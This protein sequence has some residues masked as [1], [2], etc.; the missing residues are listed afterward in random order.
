MAVS[1]ISP[2]WPRRCSRSREARNAWGGPRRSPGV[3]PT[4]GKGLGPF[5]PRA[6]PGLDIPHTPVETGTLLLPIM[7]RRR[8][9]EI[10]GANNCPPARPGH[11]EFRRFLKN[12]G[13]GRPF[14]R[15]PPILSC[16]ALRWA[17]ASA[18]R[19]GRPGPAGQVQPWRMR[20]FFSASATAGAVP[21]TSAMSACRAVLSIA[22]PQPSRQMRRPPN[23][24]PAKKCTRR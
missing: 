15:R 23:H 1:A 12:S 22:V 4:I 17:S 18:E 16:H 20:F 5:L 8:I 2:I 14:N 6:G 13:R 21:R 24:I 9:N 3:V 7:S 11:L 19:V 10:A